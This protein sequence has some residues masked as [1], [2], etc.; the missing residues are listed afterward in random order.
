MDKDLKSKG[1]VF[2]SL[3]KRKISKQLVQSIGDGLKLDLE[4]KLKSKG[5]LEWQK[6][7]KYYASFTGSHNNYRQI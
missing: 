7:Y 2:Y 5:L 4:F 1:L 6:L 3:L